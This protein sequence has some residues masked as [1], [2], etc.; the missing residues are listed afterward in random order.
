MLVLVGDGGEIFRGGVVCCLLR[1][2]VDLRGEAG[3]TL[4]LALGVRRGKVSWTLVG[5]GR[6]GAAPNSSR[7]RDSS[8][9]NWHAVFF[10]MW[11]TGGDGGG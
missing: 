6:S 4:Y 8:R 3:V 9:E 5:E 1:M 10:G 11:C 7:N 2:R